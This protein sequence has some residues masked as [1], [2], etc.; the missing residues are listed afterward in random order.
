MIIRRSC[1]W[2]LCL[3]FVASCSSHG[4]ARPVWQPRRP[5]SRPISTQQD[6]CENTGQDRWDAADDHG[7]LCPWGNLNWQTG[8]CTKGQQFACDR[9]NSDSQCCKTLESCV[10]CCLAPHHNASAIYSKDY[11]SPGRSETGRWGSPFEYCRGK[12]RTSSKSTVHE[13]AYLDS[14]HHCFSQSGKP[15]MPLP[16]AP[17]LPTSVKVEVGEKGESCTATCNKTNSICAL[18]HMIAMN[19]CN[20]L[21]THFAC[22]AGCDN[23]GGDVQPSYVSADAPKEQQPTDCL[24]AESESQF[25]CDASHA[26]TQRLCPC[27]QTSQIVTSTA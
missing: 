16:P 10:S 11:R 13:N 6:K 24:I 23:S 27:A 2:Q 1:L 3:L 25:N 26:N 9:C 15:V 14:H 12:C 8:C 20:V 21:R 22:E 17:Q 4:S 5:L 19:H 7:W 18:Q